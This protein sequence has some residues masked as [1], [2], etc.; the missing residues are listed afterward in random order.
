M[1]ATELRALQAPLRIAT[2]KSR[3]RPRHAQGQGCST[4]ASPAR[5]RPGAQSRSPAYIRRPAAR[6]M[7][8]ARAT[9]FLR[10]SSPA[11]ARHA[12]LVQPPSD[13]E[14]LSGQVEAEGDIDFRGTLGVD[15][16][17]AF[18]FERIQ[19]TSMSTPTRPRAARQVAR[20]HRALLR[21]VADNPEGVPVADAKIVR[22]R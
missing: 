4:R 11:P 18:G 1:D 2:R 7:S 8:F 17:A 10:R 12:E 3:T 5:W 20:G 14:I 9:C 15:R 6:A 19:V 16:E 21:G 13:I 22:K